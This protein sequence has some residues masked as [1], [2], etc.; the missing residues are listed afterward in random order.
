MQC[1]PAG[2]LHPQPEHQLSSHLPHYRRL[3]ILEAVLIRLGIY[4][5]E[6]SQG[7]TVWFSCDYH[8]IHAC[9]DENAVWGYGPMYRGVAKREA[10]GSPWLFARTMV[11]GDSLGRSGLVC[12]CSGH[13]C[14]A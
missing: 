10:Q 1:Q 11:V 8:N 14:C 4:L 7:F 6:I 12:Y 3:H 2:Q 5:S 9:L 13:V